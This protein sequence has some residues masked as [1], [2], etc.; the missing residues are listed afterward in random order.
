MTLPTDSKGRGGADRLP[1]VE[2]LQTDAPAHPG[3]G[4]KAAQQQ[5]AACVAGWNAVHALVGSYA[6]QHITL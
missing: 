1:P 3:E 6:D 2:A 5:A 4:R